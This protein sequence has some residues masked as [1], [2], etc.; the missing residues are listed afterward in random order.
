MR[1]NIYLLESGCIDMKIEYLTMP[2]VKKFLGKCFKYVIFLLPIWVLLCVFIVITSVIFRYCEQACWSQ[3]ITANV[4]RVLSVERTPPT[5]IWGE[6]CFAIDGLM[7][8]LLIGTLAAL[9]WT[10]L[11]KTLSEKDT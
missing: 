6:L 3:A 4:V 2:E 9:V 1:Q 8:A 5:T 11:I 7:G 10:A